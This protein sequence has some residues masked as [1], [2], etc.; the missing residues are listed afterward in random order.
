MVRVTFLCTCNIEK[1]AHRR[2]YE[3]EIPLSKIY[4]STRSLWAF[5]ACARRTS[6]FRAQ[7]PRRCP[8]RARRPYSSAVRWT[9]WKND[10][11]RGG[12]TVSA[13]SRPSIFSLLWSRRRVGRIEDRCILSISV[14]PPI[15]IVAADRANPGGRDV[16]RARE[17]R[18][19]GV[20]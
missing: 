11:R 17:A 2:S 6:S 20:S 9:R 15:R 12:W 16:G 19:A 18:K 14:H 3:F 7:Q 4:I 5:A 1:W 8:S 13:G 10:Q